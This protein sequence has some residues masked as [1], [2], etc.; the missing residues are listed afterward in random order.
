[1]PGAP[2]R[3]VFSEIYAD[4]I[5]RTQVTQFAARQSKR[6]RAAYMYEFAQPL[7]PPGRGTPH[8]A[9]VPY[10]FGNNAHPFL[11]GKVGDGSTEMAVARATMEM[12]STFAR[13]GKPET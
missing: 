10:V 9:E 5:F 12:W 2:I 13:T 6:G 8:T 4:A 1:G 7:K 11:A 3:D